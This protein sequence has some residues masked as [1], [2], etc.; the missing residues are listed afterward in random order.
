MHNVNMDVFKSVP[1]TFGAILETIQLLGCSQQSF[2]ADHTAIS[3]SMDHA[4]YTTYYGVDHS[5]AGDLT[6]QASEA[7]DLL[8]P[9]LREYLPTSLRLFFNP[10]RHIQRS[11]PSMAP[12]QPL[13]SLTEEKVGYPGFGYITGGEKLSDLC[14]ATAENEYSVGNRTTPNAII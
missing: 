10:I 12:A 8:D 9:L 4:T 1:L 7:D 14:E 13:I 3:N 5:Y 11:G 2:P 6:G